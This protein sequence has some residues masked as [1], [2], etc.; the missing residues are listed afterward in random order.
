MAQRRETPAEKFRKIRNEFYE[1]HG[2]ETAL[3]GKATEKAYLALRSELRRLERV[4]E[5]KEERLERWELDL[6]LREEMFGDCDCDLSEDWAGVLADDRR[7]KPEGDVG[8][9]IDFLDSLYALK[10]RRRK[11]R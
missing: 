4:L 6:A 8:D 9:E 10:D 3:P 5:E 11:K 1:R 2:L 7:G